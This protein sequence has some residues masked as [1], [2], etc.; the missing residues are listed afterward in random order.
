M[1]DNSVIVVSIPVLVM[2]VARTCV[3]LKT[4][5]LLMLE[6][7]PAIVVY[8]FVPGVVATSVNVAVV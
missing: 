8:T 1:V 6:L 7:V 3:K 4:G 2:G 5:E